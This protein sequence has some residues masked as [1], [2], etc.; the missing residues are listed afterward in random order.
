MI[1]DIFK[2]ELYKVK[3][4]DIDNEAIVDF[5][6]KNNTLGQAPD[7]HVIFEE[8]LFHELNKKVLEHANILFHKTAH[9]YCLLKFSSGWYSMGNNREIIAPHKH[10]NSH[11]SA[12]YYPLSI[13]GQIRFQNPTNFLNNTLEGPDQKHITEYHHE[14]WIEHVRSGDLVIFKSGL[15]HWAM[16]SEYERYSVAYNTIIDG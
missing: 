1:K 16:P 4:V 13:D 11:F 3:L 6:K 9:D 10:V 14:Y 2:V 12:V 8:N 5:I 15:W 7:T